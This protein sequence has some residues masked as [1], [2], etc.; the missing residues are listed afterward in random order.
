M[1][2]A[3]LI[4]E[5]GNADGD[6]NHVLFLDSADS[7]V[8]VSFPAGILKDPNGDLNPQ[9]SVN[10]SNKAATHRRYCRTYFIAASA[11]PT[12]PA[13]SPAAK[14]SRALRPTTQPTRAP[15]RTRMATQ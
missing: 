9:T 5:S 13:N 10:L 6:N 12:L 8:S 14:L 11:L 7:A 4:G 15:N 3:L 2:T 1:R